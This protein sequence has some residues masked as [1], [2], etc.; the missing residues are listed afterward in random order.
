MKEVRELAEGLEFGDPW[1]EFAEVQEEVESLLQEQEVDKARLV[2]EECLERDDCGRSCDQNLWLY[3]RLGDAYERTDR[4]DEAMDAYDRAHEMEPRDGAVARKLSHL[5]MKNER[6]EEGLTVA[7]EVLLNHKSQMRTEEIGA[8]YRRMGELQ[9]A[10]EQY[11][12]AKVSFEKALVKTPDDKEALKGLLRVVAEV[13]EAQDV[14]EAR[15]KLIRSL[16]DAKERSRALVELGNDWVEEFDEPRR[17]MDT[18]EEALAEWQENREAVEAIAEVGADLGDWRRVCR[19]YFTLSVLSDDK[20]EKAENLI[21]SSDVARR[22]LWEPEKALT[23]YQKALEWDPTRLDAFTSVTSILVD[24]RDWEKLEQAYLQII[25]VNQ[26]AG[27]GDAQLMGVLWDKLGDLYSDHLGRF[28]DAVF[29]YQ[30]ALEYLPGRHDIRARIVELSEDQEEHLDVAAEH[31]RKLIADNP[32]RSEWIDR[33]GRVYLRKREVDRAYCMFR[34]LRARGDELDQKAKG[35]LERFDSNIAK[36]IGGTITPNLMQQ[37][38]FPPQMSQTM[39]RCYAV[40]KRGLERFVGESRRTYGLGRRDRV[41]LDESLAFVNF[42]KKIGAALGYLELPELWRKTDQVG[43]ING[44]LSKPGFIVGDDLLSSTH[45]RKIAFTVAKQLFLFLEPFY[46]SSIRPM[47]DLQAFFLCAVALVR[48]ETGL[49]DQFANEKAYKAAFKTLKKNVKSSELGEL[50]ACIKRLT[51]DGDEVALGPWFEAIED[52]AN[53]VGLLFCDDLEVARQCLK[54]EPHTVS[55]RSVAQR[56]DALIDYSLSEKY[57]S[58][59][60]QLGIEV[61]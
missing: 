46:L 50:G 37:H 58:L 34:I 57:L 15:L 53:R 28:D 39:N 9:E 29:A 1:P 7:R 4:I 51:A 13:G 47:S 52:S 38:I 12:D 11:E 26:E 35:F 21:L 17:A 60:P 49:A 59:R 31:L 27:T 24:A 55:Q 45:E 20:K 42:Y 14:V 54:R 22:E 25:S 36:P 6:Y 61:A 23:G 40:L 56:M 44:A 10:L 48:P 16:D 19:A 2:L 30:Q 41:D 8:M 3:H 18:Y 5:L 32:E 43:L 33:L